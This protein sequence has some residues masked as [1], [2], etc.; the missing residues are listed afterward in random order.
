MSA[1]L[2]IEDHGR[3]RLLTLNR[4]D[5]LN[6]FNDAL[7]D[8]VTDALNTAATDDNVAVVVL[9]GAGRGFSAGQDLTEMGNKPVHTDGKRHGFEPFI[10]A[11]VS[12]PKPLI[13]AVNGIGVGIGLT[14]LP[15][16]DLVLIADTARLRAPFVSLGVTLEAGNSFLLPSRIG[17]T[18]A[19]HL[20]YT[21]NWIDAKKSVEIG[22]AW[23]MVPAAELLDEALQLA[24]EIAVMSIAAL[25]ATKKNLLAT[26]ND[27][28]RAA[29]D[30][31]I[32][33]FDKLRGG[34]ANLEA[35]AAFKEKRVPDFSK[36]GS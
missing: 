32:E 31:E 22:L 14:L 3:V 27:S 15:H 30:R 13:S 2:K 12:F 17:W 7:Y 1:V 21:T 20:L 28:V 29:R 8:A 24:S 9:T 11:V 18:E 26:R 6:S 10:D 5:A 4:A 19:A 36:L 16:C 25:V 33:E 34:P 23:K 35:I